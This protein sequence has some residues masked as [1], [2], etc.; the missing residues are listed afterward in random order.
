MS[1]KQI[2][3][4]LCLS[5]TPLILLLSLLSCILPLFL[6]SLGERGRKERNKH[7]R[8]HLINLHFLRTL[9]DFLEKSAWP[10]EDTRGQ[11]CS[12]VPASS[13]ITVQMLQ[14]KRSEIPSTLLLSILEGYPGHG[15]GTLSNLSDG[16]RKQLLSPFCGRPEPWCQSQEPGPQE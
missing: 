8:Q 4:S 3:S 6:K 13:P 9:S 16:S 12:Q 5:W 14:E 7:S 10:L 2:K 1:I 11:L 15:L